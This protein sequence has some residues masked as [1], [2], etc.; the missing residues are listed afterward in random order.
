MEALPGIKSDQPEPPNVPQLF[1][2]PVRSLQAIRT[3]RR[4]SSPPT[5]RMKLHSAGTGRG[6]EQSHY[7]RQPSEASSWEEDESSPEWMRL[8]SEEI[9]FTLVI[10]TL[11]A[12]AYYCFFYYES[13]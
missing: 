13:C 12:F 10:L 2:P 11:I 3:R 6:E 9:I 5:T 7:K 1:S 4:S 8:G